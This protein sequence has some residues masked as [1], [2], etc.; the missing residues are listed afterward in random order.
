MLPIDLSGKT[1]IV[2]GAGQG[3]GRMSARYLAMAGADV[4]I[5]DIDGERARQA[6]E[7][8]SRLGV[9]TMTGAVDVTDEARV[10]EFVDAVYEEWGKIDILVHA[11]GIVLVG[12]FVLVGTE[13][14]RRVLE[15]NVIGTHV[16][17]QSVLRYMMGDQSGK[18]VNFSSEAGKVPDKDLTHYS[19]T[20]AAVIGLTR[21]IA[22][23]VAEFNINVNCVCPGIIRTGMWEKIMADGGSL[24]KA[25][26]EAV[27][28]MGVDKIPLGRPQSE[29][30]VA[31]MVLFL[32]SGLADNITA[33][34]INIDGGMSI[35]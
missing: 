31:A 25:D 1:A 7:E 21:G 9:K 13:D 3:L 16:T 27:F 22:M 34:S 35:Y 17:N 32:C 28:Q 33:Q 4:A 14:F 24:L 15:V 23:Q 2:T 26:K 20:K 11:A 29:E 19:A 18:I 5:C 30:D 8:F 6:A 10:N 12:P